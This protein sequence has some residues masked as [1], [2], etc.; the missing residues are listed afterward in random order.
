MPAMPLAKCREDIC[1]IRSVLVVA[2]LPPGE[3]KIP[4]RFKMKREMRI[5]V[6][7]SVMAG[8]DPKAWNIPLYEGYQVTLTVGPGK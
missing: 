1:D 3:R 6:S 4:R 2:L 5:D 8:N 7:T